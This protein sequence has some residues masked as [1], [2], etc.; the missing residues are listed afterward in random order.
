MWYR[1]RNPQ[2][3]G[4]ACYTGVCIDPAW[5]DF[6]AFFAD[7]GNPPPGKTLERVDNSKGY[8][9]ENCVWA[10]P[11]TQARNTSRN[12]VV[13]FGDRDMCLGEAVELSGL[14]YNLVHDRIHKLGWDVDTALS[15]PARKQRKKN[16]EEQRVDMADKTGYNDY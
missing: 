6:A 13:C 4:N 16:C 15:R 3:R 7:M 11:T 2:R 10:T 9:R 5:E 14:P 12:R 8:S 1:V